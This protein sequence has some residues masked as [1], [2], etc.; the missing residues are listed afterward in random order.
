[1]KIRE[2]VLGGF[3]VSLLDISAGVFLSIVTAKFLGLKISL[4]AVSFG[5]ISSLWLDLDALSLL[6]K[7]AGKWTHEHRNLFHFPLVVLPVAFIACYV[8]SNGYYA[9]VVLLATFFHLVHDSIGIGWGVKWLYPFS[10]KN[11]KFFGLKFKERRIVSSW[12]K[13]EQ[14]RDATLNGDDNWLRNLYLRPSVVLFVEIGLSLF[15]LISSMFVVM[16]L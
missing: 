8:L 6:K 16:A 1:L 10:H 9:T 3:L 4:C 15:L 14:R 13:E 7:G 5:I 12:T 11:Y 2:K